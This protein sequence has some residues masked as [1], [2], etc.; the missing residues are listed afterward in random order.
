MTTNLLGTAIAIAA[1]VHEDQTDKGENAYILHPL[2]IMMRLR[3]D[4]EE[5]MQIAVMHDVIE[6]SNGR[7][8]IERLRDIGFSKRV[9]KALALLTHDPRDDYEEYIMRIS[10]NK[11]A[12]L[13]KLKDLHDNGDFTRLKGLRE[14]DYERMAKYQKAYMFLKE[15]LANM[16]KTGYGR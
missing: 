14:K 13:V 5:L 3:T 4:D 6:D 11:D 8:T 10:S 9:C 15:A 2:R 12:I 1:E 7:Y 16:R